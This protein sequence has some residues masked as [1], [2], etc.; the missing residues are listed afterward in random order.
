MYKVTS[1][2][3]LATS[4]RLH[5]ELGLDGAEPLRFQGLLAGKGDVALA[6]QVP[7]CKPATELTYEAYISS[8][9]AWPQLSAE[10]LHQ[11]TSACTLATSRRLREKLNLDGADPRHVQGLL[12][13]RGGEALGGASAHLQAREGFG[14][15]GVLPVAL[16]TM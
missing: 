4:R 9:V 12:A 15:R 10:I 14:I 3:P 6:A 1:A 8:K 5:E 7:S 16:N 2:C 13:A 11:V